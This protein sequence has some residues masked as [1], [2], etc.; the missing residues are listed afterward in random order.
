[1]SYEYIVNTLLDNYVFTHSIGLP[2]HINFIK[3]LPTIN[4]KCKKKFFNLWIRSKISLRSTLES[5]KGDVFDILYSRM[6]NRL[7]CLQLRN[8]LKIYVPCKKKVS[9]DHIDWPGWPIYGP[10]AACGTPLLLREG[11]PNTMSHLSKS[12][13]LL[14]THLEC[15]SLTKPL[16]V[17]VPIFLHRKRMTSVTQILCRIY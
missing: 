9:E 8:K 15:N 2:F 5:Q 4:S 12:Q 11:G 16:L 1:M 10:R 17:S 3:I 14:L 13:T 6:E 7:L